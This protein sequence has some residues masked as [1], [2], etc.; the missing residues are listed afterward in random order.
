M[1]EKLKEKYTFNSE[2][3]TSL[4]VWR[5][6]GEL[7]K[8]TTGKSYMSTEYRLDIINYNYLIHDMSNDFEI[9]QENEL[10]AAI[11]KILDEIIERKKKKKN[12]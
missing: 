8:I 5:N 7:I 2:S 10:L 3:K 11:E 1:F 4:S 6:K 9:G 12:I